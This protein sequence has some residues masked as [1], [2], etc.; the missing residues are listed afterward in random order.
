MDKRS[1]QYANSHLQHQVGSEFHKRDLLDVLE[2]ATDKN[3]SRL[4]KRRDYRAALRPAKRQNTKNV[5]EAIAYAIRWKEQLQGKSDMRASLPA[6][7]RPSR[8]LGPIFGNI[9]VSDRMRRGKAEDLLGKKDVTGQ[10]CLPNLALQSPYFVQPPKSLHLPL[11]E[12]APSSFLD[13]IPEND[14]LSRPQTDEE[15]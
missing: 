15:R 13:K 2:S 10:N 11:S 4:S 3:G 1:S 8:P 12:P 7:V 14:Q 5:E 6:P 9:R